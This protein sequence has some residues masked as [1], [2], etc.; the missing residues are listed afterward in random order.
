MPSFVHASYSRATES[1]LYVREGRSRT[2]L[3]AAVPTIAVPATAVVMG[4][5]VALATAFVRMEDLMPIESAVREGDR[6]DEVA[7]DIP[8]C[9]DDMLLWAEKAYVVDA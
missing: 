5:S 8:L 1:S 3:T 2:S 6:G 4:F 7:R 9:M